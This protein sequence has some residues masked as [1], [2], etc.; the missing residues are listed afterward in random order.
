MK[1]T[2]LILTLITLT[3]LNLISGKKA[4]AA[5]HDVR[6]GGAAVVCYSSDKIS[7]NSVELFDYWEMKKILNTTQEVDLGPDS[8]SVEEKIRMFTKR[9][10]YVD[11]VRA[12][13]Y[14]TVS[15]SILSQLKL[16]LRD[17]LG[18]N[19]RRRRRSSF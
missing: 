3:S 16:M 2:L 12:E 4:F 15:L 8:L 13:R 7:L 11:P 6:N 5:G 9:L 14:L 10:E 1:T 19:P 18:K 17:D